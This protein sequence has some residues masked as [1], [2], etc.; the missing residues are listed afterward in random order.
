MGHVAEV[1]G[2]RSMA[3]S[4]SPQELREILN[5]K[6]SNHWGKSFYS[7]FGE[8][9]HRGF[10]KK[11]HWKCVTFFY[12]MRLSN[13]EK[14]ISSINIRSFELHELNRFVA[15]VPILYRMKTPENLWFSGVF[16]GY[17]MGA[18]ARNGVKNCMSLTN[19]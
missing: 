3:S 19:F 11:S 2:G 16:R 5:L 4:L 14:M 13:F 12:L 15:N 18:L 7:S 10:S 9:I 8:H 6:N 17:K 1:F